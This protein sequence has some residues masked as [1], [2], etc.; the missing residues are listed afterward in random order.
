MTVLRVLS[1]DEY[2]APRRG[3]IFPALSR[4]GA[5]SVPASP[6]VQSWARN[7]EISTSRQHSVISEKRIALPVFSARGIRWD[8]LLVALSLLLL[9]FLGVL[10]SDM[11][12]LYAG[13]ERVGKLSAGIASLEGTNTRLR[14]ELSTALNH[15]LLRMNAESENQK[16]ETLIILSPFPAD[17]EQL[18]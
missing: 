18:P 1:S 14:E 8:V 4:R 17:H 7:L 6:Q 9:L 16:S 3:G 12:A 13:G 15:P 10:F 5:W 11:G 2:A